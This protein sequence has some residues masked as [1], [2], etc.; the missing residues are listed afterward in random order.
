MGVPFVLDGTASTGDALTAELS[1]IPGDQKETA[2]TGTFT[3]SVAG[4]ATAR[5]VVTD[6]KKH[7]AEA[8][9]RILVAGAAVDP[10]APP[11]ADGPPDAPP[12]DPPPGDGTTPP[13]APVVHGDPVNLTGSFAMV[14]YDNPQMHGGALDPQTQCASAPQISLVSVTQTDGHVSMTSS[15]C[16]LTMPRVQVLGMGTEVSTAPDALVQALPPM[17]AD[18]DLV[19][20]TGQSFA[21]PLSQIGKASV[22]G[23]NLLDPNGPLPTSSSDP[24]VV[25]DDNDGNPGATVLSTVAFLGDMNEYLVYRRFV[26]EMHGLITS[27]NEIDGSAPGSFRVDGE[28]ALLNGLDLFVP[29]GVGLPS[30]FKMTRVDGQNGA[31]DF[32]FTDG[33]LLCEDLLAHTDEIMATLPAP[34]VPADCPQ[35]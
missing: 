23:A 26:R 31:A 34:P 13:D 33:T 27:S 32:R 8:R 11:P 19:A 4:P 18:F 25:D 1:V 20:E 28:S 9:C 16:V 12:A 2:L 22:V 17:Q 6:G 35:F 3:V 29:T 15:P 24:Q 30:T 14:S 5:L 10:P 7:V 21:P